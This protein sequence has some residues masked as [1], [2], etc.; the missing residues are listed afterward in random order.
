MNGTRRR[1]L[2]II[3]PFCLGDEGRWALEEIILGEVIS[4]VACTHFC[5]DKADLFIIVLCQRHI[6]INFFV[7]IS[8]RLV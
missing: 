5:R 2:C 8:S 6:E 4:Y 3:K 1:Q 7:H